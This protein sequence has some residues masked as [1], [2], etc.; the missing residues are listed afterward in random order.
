MKNERRFIMKTNNMNINSIMKTYS[1]YICLFLML[2]GMSVNVW[3]SVTKTYVFTTKSWTATCDGKAANWTSGQ[4]GAG[5]SNNGIQVTNK[6]T[7]ANGTSPVEFENISK[8]VVTYNTNQSSGAGTLVVKV[9]DNPIKANDWAYS[10]GTGTSALYTTTFNYATP[11]SGSV[12]ITANTTTNSIYIVQVAITYAPS[13]KIVSYEAHGGTLSPEEDIVEEAE[14]GAGVT[15]P[16]VTPSSAIIAAGW[17]FYGWAEASVGTETTTAPTIVGKAGD[18]Y[19]PDDD[20]ELHAVYAKGEFTKVTSTDGITSGAKYL[21]LGDDYNEA[22]KNV[23]QMGTNYYSSS[24]SYWMGGHL[25]GNG[26]SRIKDSYHAADVYPGSYLI[27]GSAANYVIKDESNTHFIDVYVTNW[28][29]A[30]SSRKN[31]ITFGSGGHCTIKNNSGSKYLDVF[32][33]GEFSD[34]GS[35]WDGMMLYKETTTAKYNSNPCGN[36]VSLSAGTETHAEIT[37]FSET[38]VETCSSTDANRQVTVSVTADTGYELTSSARLTFTKS[39]GTATAT[40][41]SG[42]TGSGPNYTFV[43]QFTKD[44]SGA[45]TF[46]VTATAKQSA[47]TFDKNGGEGGLDGT[48]ATYDAAM[49]DIT[50][51]TRTGYTFDG[52]WDAETDNDG[53]GNQYYKADGTSKA[54]WNKNTTS[55]T[56]LYAKWNINSYKLTIAEVANIDISSTTPSLAEGADPIDVT[57]NSTVTLSHSEPGNGRTWSGWN[58]YKTD[59]TGTPVAVNGSNQF[60]MPA[61]DVTVSVNL[62]GD[63]VFSCSELTVT[64]KPATEGTPFFIT[65]RTEQTVRSQDSIL[66]VGNGLTPSATLEFPGLPSKFEIKTRT[67]SAL[68]TDENGEIDAVAY[69]YY[70]PGAGDTSDGL[71]KLTGITVSVEGAKPKTVVLTQ[72]II[73]RHLPADFVIAAKYNGKWYALPDTMTGLRNPEPIEIAVDDADNPT[74]AYTANTNF[75]KLYGQSASTDGSS[76]PGKLYSNGE[77]IK[78]GMTNNGTYANYPLF[79]SPTGTSTLGKG[80]TATTITNNIGAQYWWKLAQKNPS[81]TNPQDAKYIVYAANNTSSLRIKNKPNQWGFYASGVDTIRLIPAISANVREAYFIEY[82]QHGGIIEVDKIGMGADYVKAKLNGN[83][84]LLTELNQTLTSVLDGSTKYNYTVN[85]GNVINFA[86]ADA[87]GKI[88]TLEWYDGLENMVGV[89]T[90]ELPK[91]IASNG[92]MK[93]IEGNDTPWSKWEVHVLPGVT[94]EANAGS[95]S[96]SDVTIK[97]LEIYPGAKVNVSTGTLNVTDLM[98]RNGWSRAGEKSYGAGKMVIDG[99]ANLTHTNAYMDLY[100]DNDQYYPLA[101]PFPVTVGDIKYVYSTRPFT[102]GPTGE[103][104]LRYYDGAGRAAGNPLNWKFYGA[105]D[106]LGVPVTL[107]PSKGYAIAVK[108]PTGKAFSVIRLPLTFVDAWTTGGEHGS[109]EIEGM[110]Y[111]KN[112][113]HVN[114]YGNA[115]T[116]EANKGWNLIGNPYMGVFNGNDEENFSGHLLAVKDKDNPV[117]D[118]IR[119]VTMPNTSFTDYTQVNVTEANMQPYSSFLIQAKEDCDL[120]FNTSKIKPSLAPAQFRATPIRMSEQEAYI[121]LSNENGSDQMG[122]IIGEDYT[123]EYETN[124]DLAK[125]H[126]ELNTLKTYMVYDE[127]DMAYVAINEEL[128]KEWIP[129]SVRIPADG[130]YTFSLRNISVINELEGIYLNDSYTNAVINL[131]EQDYTFIA[132]AGTITERFS[133]NAIAGHRDTPTEIDVLNA[134]GDIHGDKPVKFIWNDKVFIWLNGAIYDTTGKRVK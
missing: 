20:I 53:T 59:D 27:T 118:K 105:T 119:Y 124:A 49:P 60:T 56:T 42:P 89:T 34:N 41:V 91:I 113:V 117:G 45:G 131:I 3:S 78:L 25:L 37:S 95:F 36:I 28:L 6:A 121:R 70:T 86:A 90:I 8:I 130:E 99:S 13:P 111:T 76:T 107:E 46:S 9:G 126:G 12:T 87:V 14:G 106:C 72:D 38:G 63:F 74:I 21:I 23:W 55:A 127:T 50:P 39:S 5:F 116:K 68:S 80:G 62:Y 52:Y 88:L 17:G 79:G 83:E 73:G 19:Y 10:T 32:T 29:A 7:G 71:D 81:I 24:G 109:V 84:S 92:D 43:Y 57:Y 93:S 64:A 16:E 75:Y 31:T 123:A 82:G 112:T 96:S 44:D 85:F 129:V 100:I 1:K 77:M 26:D 4:D 128:A 61:Y 2:L 30:S 110:T 133:I 47:I 58:A 94:L 108:R 98:L 15:L 65:S 40:Y 132:E 54:N 104:R 22:R 101:V 134:G 103:I 114:A 125:M 35:A 69:I 102:V 122:L 51:P 97:Q 120:V 115:M 18:T 11:E 66:V 67:G 48:T 33:T